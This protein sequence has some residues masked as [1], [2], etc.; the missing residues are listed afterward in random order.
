MADHEYILQIAGVEKQFPGVKALD[1]IDMQV[2][3]GEI[4]ALT[5]ENGAGKST[6]MKILC[7][8]Y[9]HGSYKGKILLNGVECAF[10]SIHDSEKAGIAII[11]Q[12]LTLAKHLNVCEN[13]FL[14]N[15]IARGGV[16]NWNESYAAAD[17]L[18]KQVHLHVSADTK[19]AKLGVGQQ[20]LLEIAKALSKN[21]KLLILDEP[22]AAL[23]IQETD[24]L[25][26]L[27]RRLKND[28]VTCIY[29][30][31]KLN[32]VLEIADHVTVIRDGK[33]IVTK[34]TKEL[35]QEALIQ[36]MVGRELTNIYPQ[37]TVKPTEETVLEIRNWNVFDDFLKTRQIIH[38]ASFQ[39]RKGEILGIAGLMG[40]GRTELVSSIFGV[41]GRNRTT[42]ELYIHNKRVYINSPHDAIENGLGCVTE[43]RKRNGLLLSK[44]I[45]MN[46][47]LAHLK[48]FAR[49]KAIDESREIMEVSA[50]VKEMGVKTP[51]IEQLVRNL[52]G[53]NQQKVVL[54]KWMMSIPDVLIMDEPTRG[55]DVGAKYE[56]Y[57]LMNKLTE[58]G[59]SI[60]MV[61]SEMPEI[62]GMSDR[63]LTMCEGEITGEFAV[64]DATQEILLQYSMG[65]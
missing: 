38:N 40:A 61:S 44:D 8:L 9:P 10:R 62:L 46:I 26:N 48:S 28:G 55:I 59:V 5:G 16:I 1:G 33:T 30:S 49:G 42:G 37:R 54:A 15:E 17:K 12:E 39:L 7:G 24:I 52:S 27:L 58:Q 4:H 34:P 6:L 65:G 18:L 64:T 51:S 57:E 60:I 43:D 14:G 50:Q 22:T 19:V 35:T 56:I 25:L 23:T 3:R 45:R 20:Q 29:I 36:Y 13:I 2:R 11:F 21:S 53:G 41:Y 63:I 31:H 47:S 32:E